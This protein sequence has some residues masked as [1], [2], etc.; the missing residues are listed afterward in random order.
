MSSKQRKRI[1]TVQDDS[2]EDMEEVSQT[3]TLTQAQKATANLSKDVIN[4]MVS[5]LVQYMLIMEQKKIP[6]KRTDINKHVLKDNSKAYTEIFRQAKERLKN[7]FG[8]EVTE[9]ELTATKTK[10]KV[11]ILLNTLDADTHSDFVDMSSEEPRMTLLLIVL[12]IIF[13]NQGQVITDALLWHILQKLDI[14]CDE[15]KD[16]EVFGDVKRILTIDFTKQMYLEYTKIPNS[17][18]PIHEFRWGLRAHKEISKRQILDFVCK[19]YGNMR[20]ENW[21]TQYREVI[22]SEGGREDQETAGTSNT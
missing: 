7:V 19:V 1:V 3:Q 14:N 10:N 17:E 6:I 9:L 8:L 21:N 2:E 12:S 16:H 11:Y 13:M 22:R 4:K 5:E 18:T 15:G 20:P